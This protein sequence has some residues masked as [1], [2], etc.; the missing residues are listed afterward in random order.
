MSF[1]RITGRS[2]SLPKPNYFPIIP[3][4]SPDDAKRFCRITGKSYGLPSH[5]FIPVRLAA[6]SARKKCRVTNMAG[7]LGKH[8][9]APDI[10][11][12]K[13]KHIVLLDYRY[14]M[15]KFDANDEAHKQ[16][17]QIFSEKV[18]EGSDGH[19]VYRV[20]EKQCNL[21]FPARLEEAIRDGDVCDIM[22][23]KDTDQILLRLRSGL[24]VT[25]DLAD[26][27][28]NLDELLEGEGPKEEVLIEREREIEQEKKAKKISKCGRRHQLKSMAKI[29]EDKEMA[30]GGG[31]S[32][33]EDEVKKKSQKKKAKVMKNVPKCVN[34]KEVQK[35][36]KLLDRIVESSSKSYQDLI[37]PMLESWDWDTYEWEAKNAKTSKSTKPVMT[38][39]MKPLVVP[40]AKVKVKSRIKDFEKRLLLDNTVGFE[41]IPFVGQYKRP[42]MKALVQNLSQLQTAPPEMMKKLENVVEKFQKAP[43]EIS[44]LL[45]SEDEIFEVL[46]NISKGHKSELNG[47]PGLQIDIEDRRVFL[48]G[49]FILN[50]KGEEIFCPG[51]AT[52][53][54]KGKRVFVPGLATFDPANYGSDGNGIS[55]IAGQVMKSKDKDAQMHFQAGQIVDD[56]FVCGQ[57]IYVNDKPEFI[58]G[59]KWMGKIKYFGYFMRLSH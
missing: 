3:P 22:F 59:E 10:S 12:G 28:Q 38:K 26:F 17:L 47:V 51:Q 7:V 21:V 23:A 46:Q 52:I 8:H 55:F 34:K 39:K 44:S 15:P 30:N 11:Y 45:P 13:R 24:T 2:R 42:D 6:F 29:F 14:V 32:D 54:E 4:I 9:Y 41:C 1:C 49:E 57:T 58:E 25:L 56:E 20:E 50:E 31:D 37:K 53:N 5:H 36:K 43:Y 40:P 19:F 18:S 27:Q 16:L 33:D 48:A 35:V